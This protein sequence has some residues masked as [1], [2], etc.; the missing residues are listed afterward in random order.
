MKRWSGCLVYEADRGGFVGESSP[1]FPPRREKSALPLRR[2]LPTIRPM[3]ARVLSAAVNGIEAFPVEV[4]VNC[5][6]G[7]SMMVV[8]PNAEYVG[9]H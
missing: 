2:G 5:G 1:F 3:L 4:E 7:D 9:S 6:W 8:T